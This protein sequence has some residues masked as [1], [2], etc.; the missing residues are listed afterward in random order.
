M[1]IRTGGAF[2]RLSDLLLPVPSEVRFFTYMM[3]C[4]TLERKIS[5]GFGTLC[6]PRTVVKMFYK[7]LI[8]VVDVIHDGTFPETDKRS[9]ELPVD[10]GSES[11]LCELRGFLFSP[12]EGKSSSEEAMVR[13]HNELW[14]NSDVRQAEPLLMMMWC[15][16]L[17]C[18]PP[19]NSHVQILYDDLLCRTSSGPYR[20]LYR[21][22]HRSLMLERERRRLA[23]MELNHIFSSVN[24]QLGSLVV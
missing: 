8:F 6:S 3:A 14:H 17:R 16:S 19:G 7:L 20:K 24:V 18:L 15:I 12:C 4:R 1:L 10:D 2:I 9:E 23:K 11:S 5:G 21:L 13:S 22:S